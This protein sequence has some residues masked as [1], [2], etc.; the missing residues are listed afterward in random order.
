M[1]DICF[2]KDGAA[3]GTSAQRLTLFGSERRITQAQLDQLIDR[4]NA[5]IEAIIRPLTQVSDFRV[6]GQVDN[7][8]DIVEWT[9]TL[10]VGEDTAPLAYLSARNSGTAVNIEKLRVANALQRVGIGSTIVKTLRELVEMTGIT[11]LT[12][13]IADPGNPLGIKKSRAG[14]LLKLPGEGS[15]AAAAGRMTAFFSKQG[16]EKYPIFIQK[17]GMILSLQK[18]AP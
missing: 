4:C 6:T 2:E 18:K 16:F 5:A 12:T 13:D 17:S 1:I 15:S 14:K 7:S 10:E 8:F 11:T 9:F 3:A